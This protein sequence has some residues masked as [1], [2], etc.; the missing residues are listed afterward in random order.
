MFLYLFLMAPLE[1]AFGYIVLSTG[2]GIAA[3][4]RVWLEWELSALPPDLNYFPFWME[5]ELSSLPS[6][7]NRTGNIPIPGV[8]SYSRLYIKL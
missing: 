7:W 3:L 8:D 6:D 5:W 2:M 4:P 1:R